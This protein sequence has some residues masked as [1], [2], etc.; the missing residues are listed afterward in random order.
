MRK[1]D[2]GC[3]ILRSE[4]KRRLNLNTA[5]TAGDV[6]TDRQGIGP[7]NLVA[8]RDRGWRRLKV[9]K[10]LF[11]SNE[12]I[13]ILGGLNVDFVHCCFR[14]TP[15]RSTRGISLNLSRDRNSPHFRAHLAV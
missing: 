12:Q 11:Y 3:E 13:V 5:D 7:L 1:P 8:P 2:E 9:A 14:V 4:P 15:K 10:V 6:H